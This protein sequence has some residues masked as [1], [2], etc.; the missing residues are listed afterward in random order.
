MQALGDFLKSFEGGALELDGECRETKL[1]F[2]FTY[3]CA[4]V[5]SDVPASYPHQWAPAGQFGSP[6]SL[7][8][9]AF[10]NAVATSGSSGSR[11]DAFGGMPSSGTNGMPFVS[12]FVPDGWF[13]PILSVVEQ[14]SV[15]TSSLRVRTWFGLT[16][17]VETDV[18]QLCHSRLPSST[19]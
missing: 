9:A 11:T 14:A 10:G 16:A 13:V 6:A 2:R 4:G 17:I 8:N 18:T 12:L 1:F 3:L 5:F 15:K 19:Q 7:P